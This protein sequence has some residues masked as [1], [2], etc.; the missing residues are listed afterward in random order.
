[1]PDQHKPVSP[2]RSAAFDILSRVA[3]EGAYASVLIASLSDSLSREDRSL[4]QEI[5]LG[6]LRWQL[7]LDALIERYSGR[8]IT[9]LDD[10]VLIALRMGLY[11]L[12]NLTRVPQS[13]AVNESVKLVKRARVASAAPLVN[14]VLRK[15]AN[16]PKDSASEGVADP[17][18]SEAV[19]LSHPR[20]M[21][22]RW[23]RE[24]GKDETRLLALANNS[25]PTVAFRINTIRASID[26]VLSA[27]S[28]NGVTVR[29]SRTTAGAYVVESGP[30]AIV[31]NAAR[32]GQIYIQDEASQ[33]IA[34][35]LDVRRE[36]R[37]LDLCAA[38]GSK[39]T[40]IALLA[41]DAARVIACD[42]HHH[43]ILDLLAAC[44]RLGIE[45]VEALALDG[46]QPLP[47]I[48]GGDFFD[49][50]LVDAPCS[51]TGTLRGNPEIKWRL[52]PNDIN[53]LADLQ[54]ALLNHAASV[55]AIGGRLVYSTCSLEGEENENVV[56]RFLE[57]TDRFDILEPGAPADLV[58]SDGFVRTYPHRH[59]TDGFYAAVLKRTR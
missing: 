19:D 40:H 52:T 7:S 22:E 25:A 30:T 29:E 15:A 14:A 21:I 11:Q 49:R 51:G 54:L 20:W 50:V 2:A 1:M 56:R 46:K 3:K 23:S 48:S 37:V 44:K 24:F 59:G 43:R 42:L 41:G 27:L 47:F 17:L 33:L 57:E 53:R 5:V 36:H 18:Q 38:P 32:T 16:H 26:S 8:L 39:T 45:S 10:A 4:A 28:E 6:V 34:I 55:I 13:A 9:R 58:T 31:A 12:R 35:L